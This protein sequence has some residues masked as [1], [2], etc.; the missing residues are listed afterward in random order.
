MCVD[1]N[2]SKAVKSHPFAK[3]RIRAARSFLSVAFSCKEGKR[4]ENTYICGKK[5]AGEIKGAK[6]VV[7]GED[8][9]G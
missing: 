3:E 9:L 8:K 4:C 6:A 7:E 1:D 5:V 2:F